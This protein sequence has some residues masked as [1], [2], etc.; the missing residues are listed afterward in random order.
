[1]FAMQHENFYTKIFMIKISIL[2]STSI[3]RASS[4]FT[5]SNLRKFSSISC[6]FAFTSS[7]TKSDQEVKLKLQE[8]EENFRRLEN[9]KGLDARIIE[10]EVR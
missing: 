6:N 8:M 3:I 4:P 1:M 10:V 7:S 5:F 9:V 2:T